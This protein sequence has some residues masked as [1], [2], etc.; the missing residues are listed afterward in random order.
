MV[1]SL[2]HVHVLADMLDTEVMM[3]AAFI[4]AVAVVVVVNIAQEIE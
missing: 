4:V 1:F 2:K 3:M